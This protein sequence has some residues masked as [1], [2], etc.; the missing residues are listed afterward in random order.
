MIPALLLAAGIVIG[1]IWRDRADFEERLEA[2]E[3]EADAR[4]QAAPADPQDDPAPR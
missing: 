4:V 3:A 2:L 1:R